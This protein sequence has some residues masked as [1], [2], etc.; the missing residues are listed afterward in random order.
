MTTITPNTE[1][2][3]LRPALALRAESDELIE[4]L[5]AGDLSAVPRAR[6]LLAIEAGIIDEFTAA[7][8]ECAYDG[9]RDWSMRDHVGEE[10]RRRPRR[11][12]RNQSRCTS[13][14]TSFRLTARRYCKR[15]TTPSSS[16]RM[17]SLATRMA[18]RSRLATASVTLRVPRSSSRSAAPT[19][20]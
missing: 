4:R 18:C 8:N 10:L 17:P 12:K 1:A 15:A 9:F 7:L 14:S 5:R 20:G 13:A 2:L 16:L 3:D 11:R 6:V 19:P